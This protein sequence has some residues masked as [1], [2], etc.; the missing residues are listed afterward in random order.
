[1]SLAL[2]IAGATP[3]AALHVITLVRGAGSR[4]LDEESAEAPLPP[5]SVSVII[6]ARNERRNIARCV[7]SVLASN[8]PALEV[9]VVD[10]HSDDGTGAA[11][12]AAAQGDAR[13]RVLE[14]PQLPRGWFGKQWACTMGAA[15]ARGELLLFLDADTHQAPDLITRAVNALRSRDAALLSVFGR[16]E[17]HGFWERVVQPEV[18]LMLLTRYGS[19]ETV[20]RARRPEDVI[21]NGQCLLVR[22]DVYD[23]LGGHAAVR[24]KVAEDLAL[25]QR[26]FRAGQ[27]V[28]MVQ[29]RAQLSTH[30][31]ASL[32]E[33]VR[34]W[35][36]NIAAA[37][38][39][40]MPGGSIGRRLFPLALVNAPLMGVIPAVVLGL[41]LGG[42]LS[43]SWLVWSAICLA[44]G[45]VGRAVI[46]LA[47][48]S[49]PVVYALLHPIGSAATLYIAL[50]ALV[51][52]RR[53]EWKGREYIAR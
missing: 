20:G 16:Q 8:Y 4:S 36:K 3:W 6:P 1:M 41:A 53:V 33:L 29:G 27:T 31:Y 39:D 48:G 26:F 25:A 40:A 30:M 14:T 24:D 35:G 10:D 46:Y 9:F 28:A 51:R 17:M 11:A 13:F 21:A 19:T 45:V 23:E 12:L 52:G 32:S 44:I 2:A 50:R 7:Q 37:G 47:L 34:G 18:F 43:M 42:A 38:V 15:T 5:P 49:P 22:R